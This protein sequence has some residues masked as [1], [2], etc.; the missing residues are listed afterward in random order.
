MSGHKRP[1]ASLARFKTCRAV[2]QTLR[3]RTVSTRVVSR[4]ILFLMR[5]TRSR[6]L[7]LICH[8]SK[9]GRLG[10]CS[11]RIYTTS[12]PLGPKLLPAVQLQWCGQQASCSAAC[13][14]PLA[15]TA[16]PA[17]SSVRTH[18]CSQRIQGRVGCCLQIARQ[19]LQVARHLRVMHLESGHALRISN[20]A[21]ALV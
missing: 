1:A 18:P 5:R 14:D 19:A 13:Y 17:L 11:N 2:E 12:Y 10:I 3:S 21:S 15:A 4:T 6:L 20:A 16:P 7:V 8:A 9:S